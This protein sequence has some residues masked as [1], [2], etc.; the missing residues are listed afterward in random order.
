MG[1]Y[2]TTR[3][4][5]ATRVTRSVHIDIDPLLRDGLHHSLQGGIEACS[6]QPHVGGVGVQHMTER[7]WLQLNLV[8]I[9]SKHLRMCFA[10]VFRTEI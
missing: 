4:S 9:V 7:L 1:V 3:V 10:T 8:Q 2:M 5:R 6:Y